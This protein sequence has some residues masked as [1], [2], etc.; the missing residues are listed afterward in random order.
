MSNTSTF[1]TSAINLHEF[2]ANEPDWFIELTNNFRKYY[3]NI[4]MSNSESDESTTTA[5][6][7]DVASSVEHVQT[8]RSS[9]NQYENNYP[10][11]QQHEIEQALVTSTS[12]DANA[13]KRPVDTYSP[14]YDPTHQQNAYQ[15]DNQYENQLDHQSQVQSAYT[16]QMANG[17]RLASVPSTPLSFQQPQSQYTAYPNHV[18]PHH[19]H[20]TT[21]SM[22]SYFLFVFF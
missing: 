20:V 22:F 8:V 6:S 9:T 14:P 18:N 2:L 12:N 1:N 15:F 3:F 4:G 21:K 7:D 19:F 5:A 11:E 16:S 17:T 13:F 10:L